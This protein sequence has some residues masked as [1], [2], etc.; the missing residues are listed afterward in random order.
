LIEAGCD[1]KASEFAK[2]KEEYFSRQD[3]TTQISLIGLTKSTFL[4]SR[5][6][7]REAPARGAITTKSN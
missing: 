7:P 6:W 5:F 1:E 3:W 4:R 2:R